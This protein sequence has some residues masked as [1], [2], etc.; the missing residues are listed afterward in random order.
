[1]AIKWSKGKLNLPIPFWDYLQGYLSTSNLEVLN[2]EQTH[3]KTLL[4]LA[5]HHGDPFDPMMIVQ[6]ITEEMAIISVDSK[7][8]QYPIEVI[9]QKNEIGHQV[10]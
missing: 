3:I 6:A 8:K 2:L 7:F 9:W 10:N 5:K 1:M 4:S